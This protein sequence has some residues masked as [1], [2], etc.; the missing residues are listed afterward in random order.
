MSVTVSV[1]LL[2]VTDWPCVVRHRSL[3]VP[4]MAVALCTPLRIKASVFFV[5]GALAPLYSY[6]LIIDVFLVFN[7]FAALLAFASGLFNI[8]QLV[9]EPSQITGFLLVIEVD[10]HE[11]I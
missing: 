10:N 4:V 2:L 3:L 7:L 11:S 1:I 6:G 9:L 5:S 8:V